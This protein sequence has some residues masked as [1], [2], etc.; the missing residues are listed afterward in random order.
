MRV[1]KS[2]GSWGGKGMWVLSTSAL[3][4]GVPWALAFV[5]EQQ[6]LEMEREQRAREGAGEVS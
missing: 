2:A 1:V 3:M 6:V 5:E 4:V